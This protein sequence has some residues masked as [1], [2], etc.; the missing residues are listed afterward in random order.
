M[1]RRPTRAELS[2]S[3]FWLLIIVCM[4]GAGF[5]LGL[6]HATQELRKLHVIVPSPQEAQVRNLLLIACKYSPEAIIKI[7][8][9][10]YQ[11]RPVEPVVPQKTVFL[12]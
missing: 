11:C 7:D 6:W 10:E 2:Q 3:F 5:A 1:L 12:I 8:G 4:V 9:K